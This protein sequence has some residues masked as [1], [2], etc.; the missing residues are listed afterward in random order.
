MTRCRM[1]VSSTDDAM[2]GTN[3][4]GAPTT[5]KSIPPLSALCIK[6]IL[7]NLHATCINGLYSQPA[8]QGTP[9]HH[10]PPWLLA[11]LPEAVTQQV[12]VCMVH[13]L[14]KM[15][16]S[17]DKH[18]AQL[19][20]VT[21]KCL[22]LEVAADQARVVR[23]DRDRLAQLLTVKSNDMTHLRRQTDAL[24]KQLSNVHALVTKLTRQVDVLERAKGTADATV[25]FTSK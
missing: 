21:D 17:Y 15:T 16:C 5:N 9:P 3:D 14:Q 23:R 25:R 24:Q 11:S 8:S 18:K 19:R 6:F 1:L 22:V 20:A 7:A 10:P 13:R 12:M 4:V 2:M